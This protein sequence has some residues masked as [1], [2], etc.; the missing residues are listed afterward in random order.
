[1]FRRTT[2]FHHPYCLGLKTRVCWNTNLNPL[3]P[4]L[5][6]ALS[7]RS[8]CTKKKTPHFTITKINW[9]TLFWEIIAVYS[10]NH[11]KYIYTL[12]G[13]NAELLIVK[14]VVHI[15]TTGL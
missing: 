13:Q 3:K 1:M 4:K 11:T 10:E 12:C 7:K 15:G 6:H 9:L 5:V 8:V 14:A 2:K